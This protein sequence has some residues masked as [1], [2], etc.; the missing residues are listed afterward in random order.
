LASGFPLTEG[1]MMNK[2]VRDAITAMLGAVT[3][4]AVAGAS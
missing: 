3:V 2:A 4:V 1:D